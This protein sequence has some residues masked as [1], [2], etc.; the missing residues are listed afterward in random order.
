MPSIEH[1]FV[2]LLFAYLPPCFTLRPR[3]YKDKT[4]TSQSVSGPMTTEATAIRDQAKVNI[5]LY[6]A[7]IKSGLQ[8]S[9]L[10]VVVVVECQPMDRLPLKVDE[11]QSSKGKFV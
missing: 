8:P 3:V 9:K 2:Q 10:A 4:N 11:L 6:S 7:M 5:P 1:N